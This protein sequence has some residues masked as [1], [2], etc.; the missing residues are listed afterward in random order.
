M[1]A[2]IKQLI[3]VGE[4]IHPE[5]NGVWVPGMNRPLA[6]ELL[7]LNTHNRPF[8]TIV[9]RGLVRA[10]ERGEWID[11]PEPIM[12]MRDSST[13]P[14]TIMLGQ[15]QHRLAAVA[16]TNVTVPMTVLWDVPM[17]V[18][19]ILDT[20][21]RRSIGDALH[22][23]NDIVATARQVMS[24]G[25]VGMMAQDVTAASLKPWVELVAPYW[26]KL[27]NVTGRHSKF[28]GSATVRAAAVLQ[29]MLHPKHEHA[30][31]QSYWAL[32][33]AEFTE[34]TPRIAALYKQL[35]ARK[36]DRRE[37]F[38]RL[39]LGLDPTRAS[40]PG[41]LIQDLR[42]SIADLRLQVQIIMETATLTGEVGG[43]DFEPDRPS[44]LEILDRLEGKDVG[45]DQLVK[46]KRRVLRHGIDTPTTQ[47]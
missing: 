11:T 5:W 2:V 23:N 17:D 18:Y 9:F 15:G 7:A 13:T 24:V 21:S 26:Q 42:K 30:I 39:I 3:K 28:W 36:Y 32:Y 45:A 4:Q 1:H 46:A 34:M 12:L 6:R 29:M 33:R 19:R 44:V 47:H 43:S 8:R 41:I 10:I 37:T 40:V 38:I 16:F 22:L 31:L 25:T 14:D 20:Q 35:S 27:R